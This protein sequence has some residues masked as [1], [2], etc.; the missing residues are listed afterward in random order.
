MRGSDVAIRRARPEDATPIARLHVKT[1]RETYR[2]LAPE[3]AVRI[4]DLPYRHAV[5]VKML[6]QAAR[7]V[8]VGAA[9]GRIVAIGSSGP[10]TVPAL[11]PHGEISYLYVDAALAG[12]GVGRRMMAALAADLRERGFASAALGV[13]AANAA[14]I[15][16][17]ERLGGVCA[18]RYADPGPHWRSENLIYVWPDLG[19]LAAG[20]RHSG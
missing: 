6:E 2:G 9:R 1:W 19:R 10:A 4:L 3:S 13:V 18:G 12:R 15:A 8:L 17:Y 11:E 7:T 14:A 16:F 20:G 5:W